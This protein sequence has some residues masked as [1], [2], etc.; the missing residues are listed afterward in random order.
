MSYSIAV[1]SRATRDN[2]R[3]IRAT[4]DVHQ[5]IEQA[6]N[7]VAFSP[8]QKTLIV[9]HLEK[10]QYYF[11]KTEPLIKSRLPADHYLFAQDGLEVCAILT[12]NALYFVCEDGQASFEASMTAHEFETSIKA[13]PLR[14]HFSVFDTEQLK[15][16]Q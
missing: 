9:E 15:N 16:W 6:A 5:Y 13:S 14:G 2:Y 1:Y 4:T 10:R 3:K 11:W 7:W 8:A 12:K